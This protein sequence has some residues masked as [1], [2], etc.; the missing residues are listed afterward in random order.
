MD[1]DA[2][3]VL[4]EFPKGRFWIERD[5]GRMDWDSTADDLVSGEIPIEC[6]I[7]VRRA[8]TLE[9]VTREMVREV[10]DRLAHSGA[11]LEHEQYL[12]IEKHLGTRIAR[13]FRRA[14]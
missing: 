2:Y 3:W 7:E 8:W 9:D 12:G 5:Q 4:C 14:A 11:E 6:L 1:Q 10:S 13:A